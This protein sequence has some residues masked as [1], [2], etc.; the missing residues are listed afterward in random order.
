MWHNQ[1]GIARQVLQS[2]TKCVGSYIYIGTTIYYVIFTFAQT[3]TMVY[4]H[5]HNHL[6]WLCVSLIN[7]VMTVRFL[8]EPVV[9]QR[10]FSY[11]KFRNLGS[12]F[13]RYFHADWSPRYFIKMAY[14]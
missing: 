14:L 7:C 13:I 4:L 10:L 8:E 6:L 12:R 5:L 11:L 1:L 2:Y 3:F 9:F